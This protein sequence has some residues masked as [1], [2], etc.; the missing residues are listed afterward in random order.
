[1]A[2]CDLYASL[3]RS[4][5]FGLT[6]AEAMALGKPVLATGWSGNLEFMHPETTWLIDYELVEVEDG[7]D[8]Y[9]AGQLWAEPDL[10]AAAAEMRA[11]LA[12]PDATAER[13]RRASKRLL[14]DHAPRV[15]GEA[16]RARSADARPPGCRSLRDRET[17]AARKARDGADRRGGASRP[18]CG[19]LRRIGASP[20]PAGGPPGHHQ[21]GRTGPPLTSAT[22]TRRSSKP[23][24]QWPK[25][26]ELR[27]D[28]EAARLRRPHCRR[29]SRGQRR[30]A[31]LLERLQEGDHVLT[32]TATS[33]RT[34]AGRWLSEF[35]PFSKVRIA[36]DRAGPRRAG[37]ALDRGARR[38]RPSRTL[39]PGACAASVPLTSLRRP[40]ATGASRTSSGEAVCAFRGL[41]ERYVP[42]L[43][44]HAPVVD[45]GAGRGELLELL[46]DHDIEAWGVDSDQGMVEGAVETGLN[47]TM[48][49][50]IEHLE[51]LE[52]GSLGAVTAIHVV[53]HLPLAELE[54]FLRA[55]RRAL[56]AGGLLVFETVNPHAAF[57]LKTFWVDPTHQHPL[58]PRPHS[59]WRRRPVSTPHSSRTCGARAMSRPTHMTRTPIRWSLPRR[60]RS[61]AAGWWRARAAPRALRT[62]RRCSRGAR[63]RRRSRSPRR[64]PPP[65]R[66]RDH[67]VHA[68]HDQLDRRVIRPRRP[69]RTA[70][71]A[72]PPRSRRARSPHAGEGSSRQAARPIAASTSPARDKPRCLDAVGHALGLDRG[73][74]R[75]PVRTVA[76][77]ERADL[78]Q[79]LPG[80]S[81]RGR[82]HGDPLVRDVTAGEHH[83]LFRARCSSH[84][85]PARAA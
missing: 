22:P 83:E 39:S 40:R 56:R 42:L 23:S 72:R 55:S 53:E 43:D 54:R 82:D 21:G 49:D 70:S 35:G 57:A 5:G 63:R 10:D 4:E 2:S 6:L 20:G 76:E 7:N 81:D 28:E 68:G 12:N 44:G 19:R 74:Q 84:G 58:F 59:S 32:W 79:M 38:S 27:I 46:R 1:M 73:E 85:P 18:Q 60:R 34:P 67:P 47:I 26:L 64:D 31:A 50:G 13:A 15:V 61:P 71:P 45:V 37:G 62:R 17:R 77:H 65:V 14:A 80:R 25:G 48:A 30:H 36:I 51:A 3:H 24:G 52:P 9:D 41:L 11:V 75:R 33:S 78:R 8:P 29:P 16:M 66:G 69:R